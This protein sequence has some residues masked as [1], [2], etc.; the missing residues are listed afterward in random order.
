MVVL[1]VDGSSVGNPDFGGLVRNSDGAWLVGF[2]GTSTSLHAE[3]WALCQGLTLTWNKGSRNVICYSDCQTVI[4]LVVKDAPTLF[5]HFAPLIRSIQDL[6]NRDWSVTLQH[7]FG[8]GKDQ[9]S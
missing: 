6:L 4:M 8:Q 3:L 5:H 7:S 1:N 9:V 2:I